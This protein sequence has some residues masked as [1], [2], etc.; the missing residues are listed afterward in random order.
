MALQNASAEKLLENRDVEISVGEPWN[1]ESTAGQSRL[2]GKILSADSSARQSVTLAVTPFESEA[3]KTV[4]Q[5]TATPRY[6]D[7]L[8]DFIGKLAG[9]GMVPANLSYADQVPKE[10]MPEGV[11]RFLIGSVRLAPCRDDEHYADKRTP[12]KG[13][14]D[15]ARI[16]PSR[17][18]NHP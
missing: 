13:V 2:D 15:A 16:Q 12:N 18:K 17:Q 3:G 7:D 8:E 4:T 5:L 11:S 6:T 10:S 1:F 9:E 14:S